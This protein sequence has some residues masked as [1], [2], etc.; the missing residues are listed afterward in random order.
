MDVYRFVLDFTEED[1]RLQEAETA[2]FMIAEKSQIEE[3]AK[4]GIFLHYDSI[5]DAFLKA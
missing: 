2:G 4:E 3:F 1:I 5:K